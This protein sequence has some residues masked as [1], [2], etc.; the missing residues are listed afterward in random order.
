[1]HAILSLNVAVG[2]PTLPCFCCND[3]RKTYVTINDVNN[4]L[5]GVIQTAGF[6]FHWL[7]DQIPPQERVVLSALAEGG[8]EEGRSLTIDEIVKIYQQ[9]QIPLNR[10]HLLSSLENLRD[11]DIVEVDDSRDEIMLESSRFRISVGLTRIWL[12]RE[13]PLDSTRKK[14]GN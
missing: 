4:V 3:G 9:N 11:A 8:K 7:W 2:S 5:D 10:E 1:M 6:H 12:L 14:L 13:N